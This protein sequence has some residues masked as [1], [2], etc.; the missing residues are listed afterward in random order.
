M[1][2]ISTSQDN[3]TKKADLQI[4]RLIVLA[5]CV[6]TGIDHTCCHIWY[7]SAKVVNTYLCLKICDYLYWSL[8]IY[9]GNEYT[10]RVPGEYTLSVCN[11]IPTNTPVLEMVVTT[12]K[13]LAFFHLLWS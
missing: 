8:G 3:K 13:N 6:F 4:E 1:C 12:F 5:S 10:G 11:S 9:S 2:P 7:L